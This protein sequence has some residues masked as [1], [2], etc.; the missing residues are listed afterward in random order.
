MLVCFCYIQY[1]GEFQEFFQILLA[2]TWILPST[3]NK[4]VE[5]AGKST[6]RLQT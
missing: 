2:H 4:E 6:G 1:E 5:E 3:S